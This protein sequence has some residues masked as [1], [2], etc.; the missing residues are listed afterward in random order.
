MAASEERDSPA[1]VPQMAVE[2]AET[3]TFK[4]LVS[5]DDAGFPFS[6]WR[7]AR[8]E[9]GCLRYRPLVCK[10]QPGPSSGFPRGVRSSGLGGGRAAGAR[11]PPFAL[12][13]STSVWHR[14]VC[15]GCCPC[16]ESEFCASWAL[17]S[18]EPVLNSDPVAD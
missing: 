10:K 5:V 1:E 12:L 3:K 11:E 16:G 15:A 17:D 2:E 6:Y 7:Q 9:S 8:A 14:C 13:N 4:D 18:D